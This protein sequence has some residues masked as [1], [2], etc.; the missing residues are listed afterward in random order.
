LA[1]SK[2]QPFPV[3]NYEKFSDN[4]SDEEKDLD[5]DS[6]ALDQVDDLPSNR[7]P[8]TS[9]FRVQQ[10]KEIDP[11]DDNLSEISYWDEAFHQEYKKHEG[12]LPNSSLLSPFENSDVQS[13]II[14]HYGRNV[15][16]ICNSESA[17]VS[18][19]KSSINNKV[20]T[21]QRTSVEDQYDKIKGDSFEVFNKVYR[22]PNIIRCA[23]GVCGKPLLTVRLGD[24]KEDS[25]NQ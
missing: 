8:V 4:F 10:F 21:D 5:E 14:R 15:D 6:S 20:S 12:M 17:S 22:K 7:Y 25:N 3:A 9:S 2:S 18:D 24:L 19:I 16:T 1:W 11:M 23:T 13:K